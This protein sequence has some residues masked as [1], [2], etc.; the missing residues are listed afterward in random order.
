M[1]DKI[2]LQSCQWIQNMLQQKN[3]IQRIEQAIR[4]KYAGKFMFEI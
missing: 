4:G 3:T 1:I 2:S